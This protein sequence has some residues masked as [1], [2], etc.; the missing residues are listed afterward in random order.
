MNNSPLLKEAGGNEE[1][2]LFSLTSFFQQSGLGSIVSSKGAT[3]CMQRGICT[4]KKLAIMV[5]KDALK[6]EELGFD[7]FD[8]EAVL[9]PLR[10]L[11]GG[12][13]A[14]HSAAGVNSVN[15]MLRPTDVDSIRLLSPGF[16]TEIFGEECLLNLP[17]C[18]LSCILP[19]APLAAGK[20]DLEDRQ[21]T[22]CDFFCPN[23]V[24]Q[25]RQQTR[26]RYFESKEDYMT[27]AP[28]DFCLS[29]FCSSC[30]I[31]QTLVEIS[32]RSEKPIGNSFLNV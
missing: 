16:K 6:L 9:P 20:A 11:A 32:V 25:M 31:T 21:C 7:N 23:N 12:S 3:L 1:A 5:A 18:L 2:E 29:L 10:R 30:A 24:Y 13:G 27:Y 8:I 14:A 26:Y 15:S 22:L 4:T 17:L 28:E 19:C